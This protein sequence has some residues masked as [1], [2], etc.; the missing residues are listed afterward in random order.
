[1]ELNPRAIRAAG[2]NMSAEATMQ[3]YDVDQ[4][5]DGFNRR[6]LFWSAGL[7]AFSAGWGG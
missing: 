2:G 5:R 4:V 3:S 1:M 6:S 7:A